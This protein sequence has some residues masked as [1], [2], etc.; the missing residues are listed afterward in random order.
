MR[1]EPER[2]LLKRLRQQIGRT[3]ERSSAAGCHLRSISL[4]V[5]TRNAIKRNGRRLCQNLRT[6]IL[7]HELLARS[8]RLHRVLTTGI[9][10]MLYFTRP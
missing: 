6:D 9:L 10:S 7:P 3:I 2:V 8:T 5:H 4:L 1:C